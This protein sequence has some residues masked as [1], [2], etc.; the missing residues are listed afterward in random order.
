MEEPQWRD[1]SSKYDIIGPYFTSSSGLDA[2]LTAA[3]LYDTM[4]PWNLLDSR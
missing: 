3:C 4:G 1:I 2:Q